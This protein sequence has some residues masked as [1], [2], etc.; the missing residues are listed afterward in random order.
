MFHV[1][2]T[3]WQIGWLGLVLPANPILICS[4]CTHRCDPTLPTLL[5]MSHM[6]QSNRHRQNHGV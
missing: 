2:K 3:D 4:T 1:M 6:V 5:F